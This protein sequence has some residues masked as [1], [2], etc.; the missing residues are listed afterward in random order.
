[1]ILPRRVSFRAVRRIEVAV[2]L[3]LFV[4]A[5]LYLA[6]VPL[7]PTYVDRFGLSTAEAAL[8]MAVLPL[9]IVTT[10]VPLAYLGSRF[11]NRRVVI[12][13]NVLQTAATLVFAFAPNVATLVAAR[14]FQGLGSA[15][16]WSSALAWLTANVVPEQRGLAIGRA[17]GYMSAGS[18]AGPAVGA[19]GGAVSTEVAFSAVALA[20]LAA[21]TASVAAPVGDPGQA[22]PSLVAGVQAS[23]RQPLVIAAFAIATGTAVFEAATTLLAPLRLGELGYTATAIGGA[24]V[25]GAAVGLAV[26]QPVGRMV[27]RAG[28][29]HVGLIGSAVAAAI[30]LLLALDPGAAA[31]LVLLAV[32]GPVFV[33]QAT[34]V[35]P[36]ST[37]GA[38]I[39]R[40]P[41]SVVNGVINLSWSGGLMVGQVMVGALAEALGQ[42]AAYLAATVVLVALVLFAWRLAHRAWHSASESANVPA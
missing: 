2:A 34:S 32:M 11:G 6:V 8:V 31:I 39:A 13:G 19:L 4:E 29:I 12:A 28:A 18:I 15:I 3:S 10:S 5:M 20:T 24:L 1:V 38:D 17:M 22:A 30:L 16:I 25:I 41:H 35:Y 42:T 21:T 36:L 14:A 26:S 9:V 27:D 23:V 7:L 40:I 37:A 33:A